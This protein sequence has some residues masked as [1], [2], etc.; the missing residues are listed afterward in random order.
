MYYFGGDHEE[1]E[2]G[3]SG[4]GSVSTIKGTKLR[5]GVAVSQ[6]GFYWSRVEGEYPSGAV[7][8]AAQDNDDQMDADRV[9]GGRRK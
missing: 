4:D 2:V 1:E 7:L 9:R 5:I 8:E 6:D 3:G